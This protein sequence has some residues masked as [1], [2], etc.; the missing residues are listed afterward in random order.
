MG[1]FQKQLVY[2]I[3]AFAGMTEKIGM[4]PLQDDEEFSSRANSRNTR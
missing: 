2:W 1:G 4:P 3:P